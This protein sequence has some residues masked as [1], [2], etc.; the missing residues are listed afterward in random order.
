MSAFP[1]IG[2]CDVRGTGCTKCGRAWSADAFY[3][4]R[5][6]RC[7][8]CVKAMVAKHRKRNI[9]AIRAYDVERYQQHEHRREQTQQTWREWCQKYP[10]RRAAH[11]AVGNAIRDGRLARQPCHICGKKAH[12]HHPDYSKPLEVVWLCPVHHKAAHG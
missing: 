3:V 8:E 6:R 4:S 9:K 2:E 1:S 5:P 11:V 7:I 10:E 12:A